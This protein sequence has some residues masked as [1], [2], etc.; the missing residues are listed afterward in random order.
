MGL[1]P[2]FRGRGWGRQIARYAQWLARDAA[3]RNGFWWRWM[4]E[5]TGCRRLPQYGFEV[6]ESRAVYVRF[7]E[8]RR[9]PHSDSEL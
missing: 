6:W 9:R 7:R 5:Q 3:V 4:V 2:E 1:T 8:N